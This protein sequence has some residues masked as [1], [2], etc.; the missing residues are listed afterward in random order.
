[1]QDGPNLTIPLSILFVTGMRPKIQCDRCHINYTKQ[2]R[3]QFSI[4]YCG[5]SFQM[6]D[7][8]VNFT[9]TCEVSV[10]I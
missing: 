3:Q 6:S 4:F 9:R 2:Q 10:L 1:M 5:L 7:S 8:V